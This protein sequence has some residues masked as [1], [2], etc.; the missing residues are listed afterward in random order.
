MGFQNLR[1]R[2]AFAGLGRSPR[3]APRSCILCRRCIR[4]LLFPAGFPFGT[5]MSCGTSPGGEYRI[6]GQQALWLYFLSVPAKEIRLFA[7]ESL[8]IRSP[9][10]SII[11][12]RSDFVKGVWENLCIICEQSRINCSFQPWE[13]AI[14]LILQAFCT[15]GQSYICAKHLL[16]S[17]L[18][19][20]S[21]IPRAAK[22][23]PVRRN[24]C[25]FFENLP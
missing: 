4:S 24:R 16:F 17:A 2:S 19:P 7:K 21:H 20:S 18:Y 10:A 3:F 15:I 13:T 9:T 8:K 6:G 14:S 11:H 1:K 5:G 12:A 25:P 23:A 22:R